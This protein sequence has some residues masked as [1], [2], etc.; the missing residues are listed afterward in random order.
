VKTLILGGTVFLGRHAA[1]EHRARPAGRP[2][3]PPDRRDRRRRVGPGGE[4]ELDEWRAEHR[5]RPMSHERE[6]ELLALH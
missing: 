6:A 3:L 1:A 4:A 2:A 5:P